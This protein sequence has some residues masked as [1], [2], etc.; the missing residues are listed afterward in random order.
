MRLYSCVLLVAVIAVSVPNAHG[1]E[2]N[3]ARI[4]CGVFLAS[5]QANMAA[6]ISWLRGITQARPA[7]SLIK[8]RM[9]MAE[10]SAFIAGSTLMPT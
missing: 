3:N 10:G 1:R 9:R 7:L 4:T 8:R 6:L 5:G 2:I